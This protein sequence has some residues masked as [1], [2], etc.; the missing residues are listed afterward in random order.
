MHMHMHTHIPNSNP[1]YIRL[2]TEKTIDEAEDGLHE[3]D[4][5]ARASKSAIR[6]K[7][8]DI[9]IINFK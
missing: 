7:N 5:T 6:G 8:S 9:K 4:P 2:N 3:H 1:N